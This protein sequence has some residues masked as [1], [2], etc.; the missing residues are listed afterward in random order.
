[1]AGF[2]EILIEF[3]PT[4]KGGRRTPVW[5]SSDGPAHYRPHFRVRNGDGEYLGVQ[6]VD[7][8]EGPVLPGGS[9]CATVQLIYEPE[10]CYDALAVGAE[11]EVLEGSRVVGIGRVTRR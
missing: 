11:F 8:P 4:E 1:M 6:F 10:V 2:A 5:L 3:V 7:G 9:C